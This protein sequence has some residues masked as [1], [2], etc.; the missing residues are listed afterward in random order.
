M[1]EGMT[2]QQGASPGQS[3]PGVLPRSAGQGQVPGQGGGVFL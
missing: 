1:S 3:A 2:G